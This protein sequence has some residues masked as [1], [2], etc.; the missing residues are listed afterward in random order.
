MLYFVS[1]ALMCL[2]Y[3]AGIVGG[4]ITLTRRKVVPG[5]LAIVAFVFL[6]LEIVLRLIIWS[7]LAAT[8]MDYATLNWI[9]F[10]TSTPLLL[11]GSIAL[12]VIVFLSIG[13]KTNLP[14]PPAM[15]DKPE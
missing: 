4:V 2:A 13:K 7:G 10:C 12:V 15:E 8:S 6:G 11:L 14:P 5:I 9:S 3:L 1:D